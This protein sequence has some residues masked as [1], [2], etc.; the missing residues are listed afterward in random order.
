MKYKHSFRLAF[1]LSIVLFLAFLVTS[2][3][4]YNLARETIRQDILRSSLPLTR[5]TI[6]SE[7][8]QNLMKPMYVSSSMAN[9]AFLMDWA[10]SGEKNI[11]MIK[12]YLNAIRIKYGF[13][14]TFFI[15]SRSKNYY[16]YDGK[17]KKISRIDEHDK[18]YF[19]FI[20]TGKEFDLI[21][22]TNQASNNL[23]TVFINF[24]LENKKGEL[25]GVTGVGLK[26]DTVSRLLDETQERFG[27][28]IYF[29]NLHGDIVAHPRSFRHSVSSIMDIPGIKPFAEDILRI[30]DDPIDFE[31][32]EGGSH[33][34]LTSR[35]LPDVDW[36]LI[37]EENESKA[38]E[39]ARNNFYRTLS[40]GLLA[41]LFILIISSY[42]IY[43]FQQK[44]IDIAVTDDLTGLSNRRGFQHFFAMAVKR[45]E[46]EQKTFCLI[47]ADVDGL[48]QVND[49]CGHLAGDEVLVETARVL[50][51]TLRPGD[52][53]ARWGGDEFIIILQCKRDEAQSVAERIRIG[54]E[55][56]SREG[57]EASHKSY[58]Q[59][60]TISQ[61]VAEY[62]KNDTMDSITMRADT[63]L[64]QCKSQ[65][66][67][68]VCIEREH[69]E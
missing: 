1:F 41:S 52:H 24:R 53:A 35:Y 47:L 54:I 34:L 68:K 28:T 26:F 64:Y 2:I 25:I 11:V 60:I 7:I 15:S 43:R 33:Y 67:N 10:A 69:A 18:W 32:D 8:L 49:E 55:R 4:N 46:R 40:I 3:I 61:G 22:D 62:H 42:A 45:F 9:D 63:L 44:I 30:Q 31:Y 58:L 13:F 21:V 51:S 6:Y 5:D 29:V 36:I 59:Y 17:L 66:K 50:A 20:A 16:Y 23:L 39:F 37:V 48:K 57:K 19:D 56:I 14:T 65:G 12:N 27:R 38:L